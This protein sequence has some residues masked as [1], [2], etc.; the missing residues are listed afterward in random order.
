MDAE[1]ETYAS[2][3]FGYDEPD[4]IWWPSEEA[5]LEFCRSLG[6]EPLPIEREQ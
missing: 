6:V 5:Y 4:F 1:E 2:I 3:T